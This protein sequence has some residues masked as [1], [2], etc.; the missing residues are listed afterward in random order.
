MLPAL[1]AWRQG[2]AGLGFSTEV[3][4]DLADDDELMRL[5]VEA[6]FHQVFV[7][8]ETPNEESLAECSRPE[9]QARSSGECETNAARWH[10]SPGRLHRGV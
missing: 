3:S 6:G 5:M 8:I 9:S 2:K 4:V 7:G 10:P 1:I